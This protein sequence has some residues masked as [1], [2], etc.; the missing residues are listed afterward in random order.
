[1]RAFEQAVLICAFRGLPFAAY[2]CLTR[3]FSLPIKLLVGA[4]YG[5]LVALLVHLRG[6][7]TLTWI[8]IGL[9]YYVCCAAALPRLTRAL[10]ADEVTPGALF[11][12]FT[13]A[14]LA[15]PSL[16]LESAHAGAFIVL[17]WDLLMSSYS[18]CH[19]VARRDEEP[20]LESC[21]FFLFVDPTL[22]YGNRGTYL[23]SEG[24]QLRGLR[25]GALGVLALFA[26]NAV[27]HPALAYAR[28]LELAVPHIVSFV[29]LG[30]LTFLLHYASHSGLASLQIGLMRMSGYEVPERYVLPW[31]AKDPSDF[32]RRW[33]TYVGSW[34]RQY[35]FAPMTLPLW[36]RA[37]EQRRRGLRRALPLAGAVMATFATSGL[38]HDGYAYFSQRSLALFATELF[39]AF[40]AAIVLWA[41]ARQLADKLSNLQGRAFPQLGP[42]VQRASSV[43]SRLCLIASVV[44]AASV[45]G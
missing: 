22:C 45:W 18:Y 34:I 33:N 28:S 25:R 40:G 35:V 37:A 12:L 27:I 3:R 1:V 6:T 21:L 7:Q 24:Q 30:V 39:L 5:G 16:T 32:W 26:A 17:G 29:A 43:I 15:V 38:L 44:T 8:V 23:G 9:L 19:D 11:V 42:F 36:R 31:L 14:F 41:L 13:I 4:A 2:A 10:R 20:R